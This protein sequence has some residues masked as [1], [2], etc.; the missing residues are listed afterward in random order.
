LQYVR[1]T[2]KCFPHVNVMCFSAFSGLGQTEV[3]ATIHGWLK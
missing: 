2:V 3:L 1:K